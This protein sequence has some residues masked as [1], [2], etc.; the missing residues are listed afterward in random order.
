MKETVMDID[1]LKRVLLEKKLKALMQ[2]KSKSQPSQVSSIGRVDRNQPLPLSFAQQRLWFLSQLDSAASVAYHIP[3]TICLKGKLNHQ[4]FRTAFNAIVSRH[5]SLRTHFVTID[6]QPYQQIEDAD[7][8]LEIA[9][10]DLQGI[11]EAS[12]L[13]RISELN[14][15]DQSTPFDLR[16]DPLI[17]ATLLQLDDEEHILMLTQHHIISD[18]WSVGI[19]INELGMFYQSACEANSETPSALTVQYADYAHWQRNDFQE[20]SIKA[21][22]DFW[23]KTLE[24]SPELLTLP[25]D[26]PRPAVQR[27]R[28]GRV[29]LCLDK[30]LVTSL[31]TLSQ[32]HG[33]TLFMTL[34]AGWSFV[35]STLSGQDDVVIGTPV[36][37]RPYRELE[38]L[39]GFFVNTLALRVRLSECETVS[40]LLAQVRQHALAAYAHQDLP[41]DKVVEVLRP[42]RSLSHSPLFQVM[43][44]L[45]NT[46][47]QHLELAGLTLSLREQ[48]HASSH[49]DL[50]L[51]LTETS[52]RLSGALEFDAD[53]FE[54]KT[55]AR[56]VD[57]FGNVLSA[58]VN[59]DKQPLH[60]LSLL[61]PEEYHQV[62]VEFNAT[63]TPFP[64]QS[65]IHT[66]FEQQV[67]RTPH[68]VAV[69]FEFESITYE[70]LNR[71]ANQYA[72]HLLSL[73]VKLDDRVAICMERSLDSV[74]SM[75]A[76]LKA[77]GAYLPLDPAYPVERLRF[78]L[79]DAAPVA[80]MTLQAHA[81]RLQSLL[82]TIV[83]D[84]PLTL[85]PQQA[86]EQQANPQVVG[87]TSQNMACV[88]YTSGSTGQPKGVMVQHRNVNR[89]VIN[90][91]IATT[92]SQA[93][94]AHCANIAFDASTWEIWSA[95][96]NGGRLHIISPSVLR[97]PEQ[98]CAALIEGEVSALW[99]TVGLFNEYLSELKPALGKLDY[100]LVGG[101]VVDPGKIAM[102]QQ[103]KHRPAHIINGYGP[104]ETT[105]FAA[106]YPI[107]Y[108]VDVSRSI[109]IG[110][111]MAN[112]QIYILNPQQQPVP[113]GVAG[114]LYIA[115]DGVARGYLNLP[116]LTAERF[117][118]DPFS[119]QP[120]TRMYKTGDLGRWLPEGN[121]EYF[122]R[123]DF[124]VKIRGFRIELGEIEAA[125]AACEGVSEVVVIAREDSPGDKRLVAYLL[126]EPGYQPEPAALRRQLAV[127]LAEYMLPAAYVVVTSF[128]LTPNG[129]LDRR[130][131]PAPDQHAVVSQRYVAPVNDREQRLAAVWRELLGVTQVGRDDNFFELGGHSLMVVSLL[132]RLRTQGLSL[133]IRTAFSAPVL[134]EMALRLTDVEAEDDALSVPPVGIPE[135]CTQIT[136]EMLPL[137]SLTQDEIAAVVATVEGGVANVQDIYPLS[138][139]Q[140]GIVFHHLLQEEGDTYLLHSLLGFDSRDRLD[141]FL[142]AL[143]QV[144][145][146]HDILRSAA[147]WQGI[148]HPVQVVWRHAPLQVNAFIPDG[149]ADIATQLLAYINPRRRRIALDK[150]PLF[151]ADTVY[152]PQRGQWLLALCFHHLV[153]DH[154][155]MALICGEITALLAGGSTSLPVSLPYRDFIAHTQ[156]TP[157]AV[158]EAYFRSLL[159]DV[160]TPTAPFGIL[161]I[162]ESGGRTGEMSL[163]LD[164]TLS[165]RVRSAARA[166]GVS[167]GVLFHTA[168][169]RVLS[170][171][172]GHD[173]VVFGTVLMG[174]LQGGSSA[175]R[176]MGMFI[177]TLPLRVQ[178]AEKSVHEAVQETFHGLTGLFEHEQAPLAL[179][180]R[181][182]SVPQP[183][184]LFSAILNYRHSLPGVGTELWAG[185]T[186]LETEERT[187]YPLTY[188]VDDLGEGFV[189]TAQ[190]VEGIDAGRMTAYLMTAMSRLLE[191]L[192][193]KPSRPILSLPIL[194]EGERRQLL[195]E[196]NSPRRP[197]PGESLIH[198]QFEVQVRRTPDAIAVEEGTSTLS[199]DAL[200]RKANRL[201]HALLGL[202]VR[203]DDRVALCIGRNVDSLVGILAILKAGGAY[204]PLDPAAPAERL[205]YM[206]EDAAPV[207][208]ITEQQWAEN[209]AS[210]LPTLLI[211]ELI[212]GSAESESNPDPWRIGLT[213]RHLAYVIYTSGSTGQPKGVMVEHR[214]VINLHTAMKA[215]YI[216]HQACRM[217]MNA[218]I[219]FDA[220][221]QC[222]VQLLSGH[223][224]V[225]VPDA[226]R[227]DGEAL[228]Q[229]I[230]FQRIDIVDCTPGQLQFLLD[231]GL[232]KKGHYPSSLLIGGEAISHATWRALQKI[233]GITFINVYGPTECTVN[234]TACP[235][236]ESLAISSIGQPII[237]TQIYI[238]DTHLLPVPVGVSG[239]IY[240]AGDSVARGYLNRPDLTD[241]RFLADPFSPQKGQR[242]Y[243]S[244]DLGRWLPDGNIE[245]LGRNDFQVKI[246]G[247]RIELGEIEACLTACEGVHEAV[248]IAREDKPGDKRLVAYLLPENGY[249]LHPAELRQQLSLS[250]ADY[251]LPSAYVTLESFP[252][253]AN[254][255]LDR[256]AL[257]EPDQRAVITH[258]Y[259]AP[260]GKTENTL[261]LIWCE[262]L[263]IS[264][265][266]R[267]D[268]F[269]DLGGHSLIAVQLLNRM[270]AAG[271][272]TTL[273]ALFA[274]PTLCEISAIVKDNQALATSPFDTNPVPL[275]TTGEQSPLF[276]LHE[277][278][279]DP[280]VYL[281]LAKALQIDRP[282]YALQAL[283][284]HKVV[285]PPASLEALACCHIE[286]IRRIQPHGPYHFAGW[287][288]GGVIA[289]QIACQLQQEGEETAFLGIIDSY[290]PAITR[291]V[292]VGDEMQQRDEMVLNFLLTFIPDEQRDELSRLQRPIDTQHA[293]DM[294]VQSKWLP[295]DITYDE[296][297]LRLETA[298][299]IRKLGLEYTP[300]TADLAI[301]LF[302]ASKEIK[303]NPWRGWQAV[304][305]SRSSLN[306]IPG[307]HYSIMQNPL[308]EQLAKQLSLQL[309]TPYPYDP[310]VVIQQGDKSIRPVFCIPGA[311]ASAFSFLDVARFM[312]HHT[313]I[314]ALQARGLGVVEMMPHSTVEEAADAYI[315]ALRQKDP[316]GPYR[317]I[318][319]S[320]GG[321]IAFEIALKL[322]RQGFAVA[323]LIVIDSRAPVTGHRERYNISETETWMKLV[324]IYNLKLNRE[325]PVTREII[326]SLAPEERLIF[327]HDILISQGVYPVNT[328][329]S[330]L[331]GVFRVMHANLNTCY[332]PLAKFKGVMQLINAQ[333]GNRAEQQAHQTHWAGHVES[334]N[335]Q[336]SSGNHMTMLTEPHAK[337]LVS[338]ITEH[339]V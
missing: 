270:S 35:L 1:A 93:C 316:T 210:G 48:Q 91:G 304:V 63:Q 217:T 313:P 287:S 215:Q 260:Q 269:F 334:L 137:V 244:G 8:G 317:I 207:A 118:P 81:A 28:G 6:G 294:A 177:N 312:P 27:Y 169:A 337:T 274:H 239:E 88:I 228:L 240:I 25:T 171:L 231:S 38:G 147:C 276:L 158:H 198:S 37:N 286:A 280:L 258:D 89:L 326:A 327:L 247:F 251:M 225:I 277:P 113:P 182:S 96:L 311:G 332:T 15:L 196:F 226:I 31:K 58:M 115:G 266:G 100:L 176:G 299:Y 229:Y 53:L 125:L 12:R 114:E 278:S 73:G 3:A 267:H 160:D 112:T 154:I 14:Q 243:K 185:M 159:G 321:W 194:P 329:I 212:P 30:A 179:A 195:E 235:V 296:L 186:L 69:V 57:Y 187:N 62:V 45:D 95:L 272:T 40:D 203:P 70:E 65:L 86:D 315:Q 85:R 140:E 223:T 150:A 148:T 333:E 80:L 105:T 265:V 52:G 261:A 122:G 19:L 320:F 157:P 283:G 306:E 183:L 166:L 291:Q 94:V 237:N 84:Q 303:E 13:A 24:G 220:S 9:F 162:Q 110:K 22:L 189:L 90:N 200:N 155:S 168:C 172:C 214:N 221:V 173:D 107:P 268:N 164:S 324:N 309:Q 209:L 325:L 336:R 205:N 75:L 79:R 101:D 257:P 66:Q 233:H 213:S 293:F 199:Y 133:D 238:L 298:L 134:S 175:E 16:E 262:L 76:I 116:A 56:F 5:E 248:V 20:Q 273:A 146:R 21:Q 111:P 281:P 338:Y 121:I 339:G 335:C 43:L 18:G 127:S 211:D 201:A 149:E 36:A 145:D 241:E 83:F 102:L 174:R 153:C 17:R 7:C 120:G 103:A 331:R 222:W 279:G 128:P 314:Y 50:T 126:P 139:L 271:L 259:V 202:G 188:A 99:L 39:I 108:P 47:L 77:G 151:S 256:R 78:M 42:T 224:V 124:Q 44:A 74:V 33:T 60:S 264:R 197:F 190:T 165:G 232:G 132:E 216:P 275:M 285:N 250:L 49:F 92:N 135:H 245:Y 104:T 64:A 123:N 180:L 288:L 290:H 131:L 41:F 310:V 181:C 330:V 300:P 67:R 292:N 152:D 193:D 32:R 34:L 227:K 26:H 82:P 117:L 68:A 119:Q 249:Q 167:P 318:G 142:Q 307:T 170:Q 301:T 178:L 51:S 254:G 234:A 129:K 23:K 204:V 218:S 143:Q 59:D 208:V 284:L 144:I 308:R 289:Y 246:R 141:T 46:P 192:H 130:A 219:I 98:L 322:Q 109:P 2:A 242:M 161:D 61:T 163:P 97:D 72:H 71:R 206:L 295:S 55:I 156:R 302:W 54:E 10:E 230:A 323:E 253:T 305:S 252:L 136:P 29:P 255:K 297:V 263:G 106:T 319:H 282:I 328:S 184:P 4:A 87:L 138:P 191:A 11:D 236:V